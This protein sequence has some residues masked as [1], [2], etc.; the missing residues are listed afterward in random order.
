[1]LGLA[2]GSMLF[3]PMAQYSGT[4][5]W[6]ARWS[7]RLLS[8]LTMGITTAGLSM[9]ARVAAKSG[10]FD[11]LRQV[12]PS[13]GRARCPH[14]APVWHWMETELFLPAATELPMRW[15]AA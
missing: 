11:L 5:R 13:F 10:P 8:D 9:W 6:T 4:F 15:V 1:M 14:S 7:V 3:F 12:K 2:I